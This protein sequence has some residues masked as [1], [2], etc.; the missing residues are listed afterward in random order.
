MEKDQKSFIEADRSDMNGALVK[1]AERQDMNSLTLISDGAATDLPIGGFAKSWLTNRGVKMYS[2]LADLA[3]SKAFDVILKPQ[4]FDQVKAQEI[5]FILQ[6][7]G[8]VK[9]KITLS[10]EVN[11]KIHESFE[12]ETSGESRLKFKIPNDLKPGWHTYKISCSLKNE[13]ISAKN[14]MIQGLFKRQDN[15]QVLFLTGS[16]RREDLL[17]MRFLKK[18]Y[19]EKLVHM[20]VHNPELH[21]LKLEN[22][23]ALVLGNVKPEEVP[24]ALM[25]RY[26]SGAVG[27]LLLAGEHLPYW[28]GKAGFPFRFIGV[29]QFKP[30]DKDVVM[31]AS[32][33]DWGKDT[34]FERLKVRNIYKIAGGRINSIL[35]V[36][37][38]NDLLPLAVSFNDH[39]LGLFLSDLTWKWH[40]NPDLKSRERYFAIWN[41][42]SMNFLDNYLTS[43]VINLRMT[44]DDKERKIEISTAVSYPYQ[45]DQLKNLK[46][47]LKN[48]FG[49]EELP[50]TEMENRYISEFSYL[51]R[52]GIYWIQATGRIDGKLYESE[53][54]PVN[55]ST[56][57][58]EHFNT[59]INTK[60]LTTGLFKEEN[61]K[62]FADYKP[63]VAKMIKDLTPV[64]KVTTRNRYPLREL[65]A[66]LFIFLLFGYEWFLERKYIRSL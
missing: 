23:K 1:V 32:G 62:D 48:D 10:F 30:T 2:T 29:D 52:K 45:L 55:L 49:R 44:N 35:K 13:D 17:I 58:E 20:S 3:D 8:P 6:S 63:L 36:K 56:P 61:S 24:T 21:R 27:V 18:K 50:L 57:S 14:N 47:T 34:D 39:K 41:G 60:N 11:G 51:N 43:K 19:D 12:T 9:G 4:P 28:G 66:A 42:M 25:R 5:P 40:L 31:M 22:I 54:I 59:L 33:G 38:R 16:P 26:H 15:D 7:K 53:N 64:K 65:I 46:I 37:T